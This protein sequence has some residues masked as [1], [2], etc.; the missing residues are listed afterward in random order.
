VVQGDHAVK[1]TT[2]IDFRGGYC[3]DVAPELMT[4]QEL[5]IAQNCYWD[6]GLRMRKGTYS[7]DAVWGT[8]TSIVGAMRVYFPSI[9]AFFNILAMDDGG[10][11]T[12][13]HQYASITATQFGGFNFTTGHDVQFDQ[14]DGKVIAV[15][16]YDKP[17]IMYCTSTYEIMNLETY[18]TRE[19]GTA[20]WWAGQYYDTAS[21]TASIWTS[22]T[23][24]AQ[25]S[26]TSDFEVC[27]G[28]GSNGFWIACN[29]Q[30][31]KISLYNCEQVSGTYGAAYEYWNTSSSWSTCSLISSADFN[32]AT[33]TRTIEFDWP[34]DW[35]AGDS[36][37]TGLDDLATHY[38]FRCRLSTAPSAS[39][40]CG[41]ILLQHTQ[42]LTAV[43]ANDRPQAVSVNNRITH[44]AAGNNVYM[45]EY[46]SPTGWEL[47]YTEYFLEG[48]QE[49]K[50]MLPFQDYLLVLKDN[51]VFGF[52]GT[53][54]DTWVRKRLVYGAGACSRRSA[55]VVGNDVFFVGRNAIYKWDGVNVY[56]VSKH[57]HTDFES[58]VATT[59]VGFSYR[60]EYWLSFPSSTITLRCDPDSFRQDEM[61]DG[62]VGWFKMDLGFRQFLYNQDGGDDGNFFGVVKCTATSIG[63]NHLCQLEYGHTGEDQWCGSTTAIEMIMQ[64]G[65]KIADTYGY[66]TRYTRVLPRISQVSS[67]VGATV[68]HALMSNDSSVTVS[69][70]QVL[71]TGTGYDQDYYTIPYTLDGK[72]LSYYFRSQGGQTVHVAGVTFEA[73]GRYF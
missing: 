12:F 70:T 55:A 43:M 10:S 60:G 2:L 51:A 23:E 45:S 29:F 24:D 19:R 72:N 13:Y 58:W 54:V 4:S 5:L 56:S 22:D 1:Q 18:D 14:I 61:G 38:I 37:F 34:S 20:T 21:V 63:G 8:A 33:A 16:G 35:M 25:S 59:A 41:S 48:G 65:Y 71:N 47:K 46:G 40:D 57:I 11:V 31:N 27:N 17:A 9:P 62:R 36:Y 44:L 7:W 66:Q 3:T 15:N 69:I 6:S 64:T 73:A 30:F 52:Y 53:A 28:S 49:V 32:A 67:S 26:A 42:Y 39:F 50:Q 68:T